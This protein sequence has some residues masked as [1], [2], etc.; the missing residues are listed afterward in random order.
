[1][2]ITNNKDFSI[3][4]TPNDNGGKWNFIGLPHATTLAPL[5][6]SGM[7]MMWAVNYNYSTNA[8]SSDFLH[9]DYELPR[10]HGM[11]VW[12]EEN[13]TIS[14][15]ASLDD[16]ITVN[17]QR[18]NSVNN[19]N[20]NGYRWFVLSNPSPAS[21]AID[22]F[23]K[24][25]TSQLWGMTKRVYTYEGTT[26]SPKTSGELQPGEGFFVIMSSNTSQITFDYFLQY[27][28]GSSTL[29]QAN[30]NL[31]VS[32]LTDGYSVPIEF[33]QNDAAT[34]G[35]DELMHLRCS[36]TVLLPSHI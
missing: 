36:E 7:P 25:N 10:G 9:A 12:T 32:V 35:F 4:V 24:K 6:E 31:I 26:F 18:V 15:T 34:V 23:T 27:Y 16:I 5:A 29:V 30:E 19:T 17:Y 11:F 8:W 28:L 22:K 2:G 20:S 33:L 21:L 3:N 14:G 13:A 1:M